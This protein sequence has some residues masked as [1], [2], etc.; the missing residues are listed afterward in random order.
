MERG[1]QVIDVD[2]VRL[3]TRRLYYLTATAILH[4]LV[5]PVLLG[6]LIR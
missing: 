6:T 2:L 1:G 3:G 4:Y 5:G